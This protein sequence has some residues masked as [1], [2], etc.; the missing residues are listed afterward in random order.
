MGSSQEDFL[1]GDFRTELLHLLRPFAREDFCENHRGNVVRSPALPA[2]A[3]APD[4]GT[5]RMLRGSG[6]GHES[7]FLEHLAAA[8]AGKVFVL[9]T[10]VRP[11]AGIACRFQSVYGRRRIVEGR[12]CGHGRP[13]KAV[14]LFTT[15]GASAPVAGRT[16]H[17]FRHLHISL[18]SLGN[19]T[20]G[21]YT[22]LLDELSRIC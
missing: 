13:A 21:Q 19:V 15:R 7:W 16:G 20:E 22:K 12:I 10:R 4:R 11:V 5:V 9:R 17:R 3:S 2:D 14:A 6:T 8:A 18:S 1:Q